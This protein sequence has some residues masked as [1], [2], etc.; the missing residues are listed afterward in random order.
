MNIPLQITFRNMKH[1]EALDEHIRAE[2]AKLEEFFDQI[3]RCHVVVEI[4]HQHHDRGNP[5]HIRIN[6][7]V[8]G[9][10]IVVNQQPSLHG[11]WIDL[12]EER[13]LKE[14]DLEGRHRD[15]Y[16]ALSDAFKT[17]RR[18]LQDHLRRSRAEVK[19]H[20]ETPAARVLRLFAKEGYG[21]L[22]TLDGRE[23]YFHRNS[24]M[25]EGF[26][27]LDIGTMVVY[28]EEIGE[29]GPQ[30]STVRCANR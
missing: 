13:R 2:V 17:A 30:A 11:Q 10:S 6:L 4:P 22:Q 5:F 14:F 28:A 16:V 26:D 24:V 7:E 21:F 1:S 12:G 19:I 20:L 27:Q 8:P 3:I 18:K 15:A 29:M 9:Q 23:I 25:N